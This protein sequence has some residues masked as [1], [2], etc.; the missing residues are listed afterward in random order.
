MR[1]RDIMNTDLAT[2]SAS[3][4][5]SEVARLMAEKDVGS[6]V[7]VEGATPVGIVTDRDLVLKH[8]AG[9]HTQDC[10]VKEAMSSDRLLA[11]LVTISPDMDVLEASAELGRRKVGRLPVVEGDRLVGIVSAGDLTKQLQKALDSLM[12]EGEKAQR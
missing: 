11:G 4:P 6:V 3:T 2:A 1:V 5:I 12:A 7:I 10:A 9:G 8:L